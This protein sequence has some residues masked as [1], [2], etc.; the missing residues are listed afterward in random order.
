ML[1]WFVWGGG[2]R[3]VGWGVGGL[4][5]GGVDLPDELPTSTLDELDYFK[6]VQRL[7]IAVRGLQGGWEG[8]LLWGF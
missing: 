1:G 3:L 2:C 8:V 5:G 4:R 7:R 6:N